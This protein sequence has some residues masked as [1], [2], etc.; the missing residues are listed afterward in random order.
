M[1]SLL[2]PNTALSVL[3]SFTRQPA[4]VRLAF[5]KPLETLS[6]HEDLFQGRAALGCNL[7]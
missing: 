7:D 5:D 6:K 1:V 2:L 4:L 3:C